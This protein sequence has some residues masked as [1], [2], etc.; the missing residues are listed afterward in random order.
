MPVKIT[1]NSKL[2]FS[3]LRTISE[4]LINENYSLFISYLNEFEG[5]NT[6][7]KFK[8]ILKAWGSDVAYTLNFN[9]NDVAAKISLTYIISELNDISNEIIIEEE[10]IK[11]KIGIPSEFYDNSELLP[12][13]GILKYIEI[14]G[15]FIN[16][17]DLC[18][19]EKKQ[20]IDKLPAKIYNIVLNNILK[21]KSKV[22]IFD[23]PVLKDFKLNFFANDPYLFLKGLFSNYDEFYFRDII[24]HLSKR[25][26]GQ[27]L[28]QSTPLDIEYYIEKY[29]DELKQQNTSLT[30]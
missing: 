8:N 10:D 14:S 6:F 3:D 1:N 25:I 2:T 30:L 23:N 24:F 27:I 12:I 11:L 19:L 9:F 22:I 17:S 16:L 28:L 26:D 15:I 13:Y 20:I 7:E 18:I 21:E 5:K 4:S 29:G